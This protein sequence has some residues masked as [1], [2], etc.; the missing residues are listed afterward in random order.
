MKASWRCRACGATSAV[1]AE[2]QALAALSCQSCGARAEARAA[3][4]FASALEDALAQLWWLRQGFD[5]E[6]TLSSAD[7]PHAFVP[8]PRSGPSTGA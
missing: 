7:I 4:D 2:P 6:V 5:V 8:A 1:L 3:E